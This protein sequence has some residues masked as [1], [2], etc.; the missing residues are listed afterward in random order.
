MAAVPLDLSRITLTETT[1]IECAIVQPGPDYTARNRFANI[2]LHP[3]IEFS[4]N[5]DTN[6]LS[7][8]L[9]LRIHPVDAEGQALPVEGRFHTH[10][11]FV[12][13]NLEE[14]LEAATPEAEATPNFMLTMSLLSISY[15][16]SRG[17][18]LGKVA[19]TVFEGYCLPLMDAR[20][21]LAYAADGAA[22]HQEPAQAHTKAQRA[23]AG[24]AKPAVAEAA[25]KK[26]GGNK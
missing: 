8:R 15:S 9:H 20:E 13:E 10:F 17:M 25:T 16:T 19:G 1:F 12:V 22:P 5:R 2:N 6:Y 23:L 4:F 18:I 21:L 7:V 26:R 3:G 24:K 14:Q 11:G